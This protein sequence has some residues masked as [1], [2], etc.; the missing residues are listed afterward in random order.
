MAKKKPSQ[1]YVRC[2]WT[3][4]MQLLNGQYLSLHCTHISNKQIE[5]EVPRALV[6][7][8]KIKLELDAIHNGRSRQ[9]KAICAMDLDVLNEHDKHYI[10][11]HFENI[12]QDDC[13][14]IE[15]FVM[16]HA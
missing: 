3:G 13:D 8:P 16:A 11:L 14:F 2:F 12:S 9:I 1:A 15:R 10:K 5:V 6:D 7:S 4:K